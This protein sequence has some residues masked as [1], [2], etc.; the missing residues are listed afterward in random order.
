MDVLIG[1]K[2]KPPRKSR[3]KMLEN[4]KIISPDSQLK[5]QIKEAIKDEIKLDN[6]T[7]KIIIIEES[8]KPKQSRK[9]KP[10]VELIIEEKIESPKHKVKHHRTKK[11]KPNIEFV[12]LDS[13]VKPPHVK[14]VRKTKKILPVT[15]P[16][17]LEGIY[18]NE[19]KKR[20]ISLTINSNLNDL[21]DD[22]IKKNQDKKSRLIERLLKEYIKKKNK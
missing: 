8:V 14:R 21:I 18:K 19:D 1:D 7:P 22:L 10:K 9:S 13:P 5:Q 16:H 15:G 6:K 11:V 20:K 4:F 3:K 12:I 2:I 17:V